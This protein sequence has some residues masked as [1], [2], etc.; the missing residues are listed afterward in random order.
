[1]TAP[2]PP[3]ADRIRVEIEI[4]G[5]ILAYELV[6]EGGEKIPF[7]CELNR[8]L[9]E[10]PDINGWRNYVPSEKFRIRLEAEGRT[11]TRT[12]SESERRG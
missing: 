2:K 10:L 8:D 3:A 11:M 12:E 6:A 7:T 1:M 5:K 4:D 9:H